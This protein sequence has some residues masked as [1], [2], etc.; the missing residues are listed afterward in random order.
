M[1][2]LRTV[3]FMIN[4]HFLPSAQIPD[5]A[6]KMIKNKIYESIGKNSII[7]LF[8]ICL[9]RLKPFYENIYKDS[10]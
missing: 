1:V 10:K 2:L 9:N 3:I 5:K 4:S 7:I 6:S 8:L